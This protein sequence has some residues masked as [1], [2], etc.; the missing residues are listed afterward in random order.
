MTGGWDLSLH[1][2]ETMKSYLSSVAL[3]VGVLLSAGCLESVGLAAPGSP[4]PLQRDIEGW[5]VHVEPA[6]IEGEHRQ[7]GEQCLSMLANHLQRIKI[8]VP[9]AALAKLQAIEIWIEHDN[10]RLK[11]MQYHPSVD[12]LIDNGHDPRLA[13]KVHIT[14]CRVAVVARTNAQAPGRRIAR[15]GARFS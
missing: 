15:A 11:S 12:W 3:T 9:G 6:L 5:M 14:Q 13:K 10:P 2:V 7:E 4:D 8:L 1:A